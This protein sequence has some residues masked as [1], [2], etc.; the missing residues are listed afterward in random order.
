MAK[1][2]QTVKP[3]QITVLSLLGLKKV[4]EFLEDDEDNSDK[5]YKW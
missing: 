3:K 5:V 4:G 1:S 2:W